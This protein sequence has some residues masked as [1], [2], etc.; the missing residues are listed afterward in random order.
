M[1]RT[2]PVVESV[3]SYIGNGSTWTPT[4]GGTIAVDDLLFVVVSKD[5]TGTSIS[6]TDFTLEDASS[7]TSA[8]GVLWR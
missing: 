2:L 5:G 4:V 1:A 6:I 7:A 3:T 8:A